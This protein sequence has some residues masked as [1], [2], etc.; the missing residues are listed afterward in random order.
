MSCGICTA[1]TPDGYT[2]CWDHSAPLQQHLAELDNTIHELRTT[3]ARQDT[4]GPSNGSAGSTTPQPAINLDALEAYEQLRAVII[5]WAVNLQGREFYWIAATEEAGT[6]L[7]R[8]LDMVRRQ[9]WAPDLATELAAAVRDA[10]NAT[11][12]AADK[13]SLGPC[14]AT[15]EGEECTDTIIAITG[16]LYAR[17]RTC[18]T[19]VNV[20]DHQRAMID[21][22]WDVTGTLPAVLRAL[23]AS[24]HGSIPLARAEKWVKRGNLT[25]ASPGRY[26]AK[27]VL[28]AYDQTPMGKKAK[29][30]REAKTLTK[31]S[32]AA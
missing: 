11:D 2:I 30:A 16:T 21:A 12:R 8:N 9:N 26:T 6:Y 28:A 23:K 5:G 27:D 10:V 22:A 24:G 1:E 19:A 32:H 29:A 4:G 31:L 15:Y 20:H 7:Y 3:M 17:C 25:P 18:G 14:G 13:I